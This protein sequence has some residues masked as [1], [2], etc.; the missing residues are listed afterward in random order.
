M[1]VQFLCISTFFFPSCNNVN[2]VSLFVH[3]TRSSWKHGS[4]T[5]E[6]GSTHHSP[7][8]WCSWRQECAQTCSYCKKGNW[9]WGSPAS[10]SFI[11]KNPIGLYGKELNLWLKFRLKHLSQSWLHPKAAT[12]LSCLQP[13]LILWGSVFSQENSTWGTPSPTPQ[14]SHACGEKY[15]KS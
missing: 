8:W 3:V 14:A 13:R 15:Y 5:F 7:K 9:K 2:K 6:E 1:Q 12:I 4:I 11:L 10:S